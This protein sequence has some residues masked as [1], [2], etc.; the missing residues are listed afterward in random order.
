M[1]RRRWL[2][3]PI[4]AVCLGLVALFLQV[5][6]RELAPLEDR[7]SISINARG[8]EGATF[9]YMDHFM[10]RL[11]ALIL[12]EVPE[13]DNVVTVTA[14]GFG[15][16]SSVNSGFGRINLTDPEERQRSQSEIVDR[17]DSE[18]PPAHRGADLSLRGADH[19]RRPPPRAAGPVRDPGAQH[20]EAAGGPAAL[21]RRSRGRPDL[22][23]RRRR[24]HVRQARAPGRHRPRAGAGPRTSRLF[25]SPR[26]CSWR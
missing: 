2:A 21:P 23:L 4:I 18:D 17:A 5:L 3:L 25:G 15:A 16:A 26:P 22:R 13:I 12:D 11:N 24:P 6:P 19:R 20:G 7:G 10:D 1:L 9:A 8:P 14:P